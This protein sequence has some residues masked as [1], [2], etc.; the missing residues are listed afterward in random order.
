MKNSF[1]FFSKKNGFTLVELM[2]VI[3]VV[4]ILFVAANS[5]DVTS[6][7]SQTRIQNFANLVSDAIRDAQH[8]TTIGRIP[9]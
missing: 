5:F 4:G 9:D 6:N 7:I 2:L 3:A 1:Q 8:N